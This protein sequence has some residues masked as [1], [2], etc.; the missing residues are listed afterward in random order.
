MIEDIIRKERMDVMAVQET[1]LRGL[2]KGKKISG[3]KI[4]YKNRERGQKQGGGLLMAVSERLQSEGW[5][6]IQLKNGMEEVRNERMWITV[7]GN[8]QNIAIGNVYCARETYHTREWN[9]K[10]KQ[11]LATKVQI[12]ESLGYRVLMMGDF[13]GHICEE[14]VG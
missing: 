14:A 11:I 2:E 10:I 13:N 8:S 1:G 12:L 3:Y 9:E 7:R 5:E 4:Y 6:G